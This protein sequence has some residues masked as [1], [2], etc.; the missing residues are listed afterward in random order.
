MLALALVLGNVVIAPYSKCEVL[1]WYFAVVEVAEQRVLERSD[2]PFTWHVL[3]GRYP[4]V[5]VFSWGLF[6]LNTSEIE[7]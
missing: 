1:S 5:I 4:I 2:I 6:N 3:V 7:N